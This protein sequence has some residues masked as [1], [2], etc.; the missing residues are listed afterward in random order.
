MNNNFAHDYWQSPVS[1]NLQQRKE[2]ICVL[3]S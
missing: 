1:P 2:I 3:Q